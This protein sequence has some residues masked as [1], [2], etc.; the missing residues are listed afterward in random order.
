[1]KI[2]GNSGKT[3]ADFRYLYLSPASRQALLGMRILAQ[4]KT[5]AFRLVGECARRAGL[6]GGALAKVFQ[7]LAG[8]GLL[9]S[10]RG[11]G[12]GYALA[13][14]ASQIL[15]ADIL[16]AVHDIVPGGHPCL[17]GNHLCGDREFCPV[18]KVIIEA[19]RLVITGFAAV[20]LED[21]AKSEGWT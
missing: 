1:M 14:P 18:H 7:R 10:Q 12:G 4:A 20:T 5:S 19:D 17:L 6:P 15:L 16:R 2:S 8:R 21:F 13:R 11:P 3:E 9:L